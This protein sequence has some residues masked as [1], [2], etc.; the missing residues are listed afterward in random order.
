MF[1]DLEK[2]LPMLESLVKELKKLNK[3][4]VTLEEMIAP[5]VG[6][7]VV[8]NKEEKRIGQS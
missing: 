6:W 4:L 8:D 5:Y 1:P 2:I 7:R 3:N